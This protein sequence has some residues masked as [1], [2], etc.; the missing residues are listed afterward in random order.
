M[1]KRR[2][3]ALLAFAAVLS[4]MSC[5]KEVTDNGQGGEES[6]S[7]RTLAFTLARGTST[8]SPQDT[9]PA[10]TRSIPMGDP[11]DGHQVYLEETVTTIDGVCPV[12][13]ETRGTPVY[14]ENFANM[15]DSFSGTGFAASGTT[16][17]SVVPD[18]PFLPDGSKWVRKFSS[19]PFGSNEDLFFFF[20]AP[21]TMNGVSGLT[22]SINGSQ[23]CIIDFDYVVPLVATDQQEILFSGRPVTK[24]ESTNADILFHHALTGIKF[25]AGNDNSDPD[26]RTYI[27]KVEFP[28]GLFRSAHFKVTTTWEE[29]RWIDVPGNHSSSYVAPDGTRTVKVSGGQQLKKNETFSQSFTETDIVSYQTGGSFASK[30]EYPSSF[31]AAGNTGNLNDADASMTFWLI[32]QEMNPSVV[33]DVT[34]HVICSGKDSGPVTRRIEFGKALS[35][36]EWKAGELRTYTLKAD[37]VDVTISDKVEGFEKTDVVITNTGNVDAFI[38]AHITANWFGK[39]DGLYSLAVGYKSQTS[40]EFVD[41]WKIEGTSGDNYGGVFEGLPGSGWVLASD[42]FFYHMEAVPAGEKTGTLFTKYS[43]DT[44]VHPVPEV[45]YFDGSKKQFTDIELVMDIP[46]QAIEAKSGKTYVEAWAEAGV[47]VTPV[48]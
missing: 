27:T 45:W 36:V 44:S 11:V 3:F 28:Q 46:V 15:F 42:G 30:G 34:F 7:V 18:G 37:L 19:D 16:L 25:A 39:A 17:T 1:M 29:G 43:L 22:Y 2:F 33:L 5:V 32:P 10:V 12:A 8:R 47:N 31:A 9:L 4:M 40:S 6:G 23:R 48:H 26:V 13:P 38:R 41:P 21:A 35:G 24:A 20:H 14:T